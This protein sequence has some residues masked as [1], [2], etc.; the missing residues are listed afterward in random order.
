LP[1]N[2]RAT[3]KKI[4]LKNTIYVASSIPEGFGLLFA[5]SAES[6]AFSSSSALIVSPNLE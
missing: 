1:E 3:A 6:S 4:T 2:H 5:G